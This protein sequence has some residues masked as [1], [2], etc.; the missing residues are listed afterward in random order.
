M[1]RNN[2][3]ICGIFRDNGWITE[4]TS[5]TESFDQFPG[6]IDKLNIVKQSEGISFY[7]LYRCPGCGGFYLRTKKD[8]FDSY[9]EVMIIADK[10]V[11]VSDKEAGRILNPPATETYYAEINVSRC[12]SKCG[13]ADVKKLR[14]STAGDDILVWFRCLKCGNEEIMDSYQ[15]DESF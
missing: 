9:T 3:R 12:C 2:C 14:E 6:N 4:N 8:E 7:I 1:S 5:G 13:S 15:P 10:I 11:P